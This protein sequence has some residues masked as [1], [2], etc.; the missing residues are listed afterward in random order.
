M[1]EKVGRGP[2]S[3]KDY[4]FIQVTGDA[5]GR[6][7]A[8][9]VLEGHAQAAG[10]E[11]AQVVGQVGVDA[12]DQGLVAEVGVQAKDHF[13]E[14]EVAHPGMDR[15]VAEVPRPVH[16]RREPAMGKRGAELIVGARND[17]ESDEG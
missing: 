7:Y 6:H 16:D 12:A 8:L 3:Q 9:T 13:P 10:Q 11:V 5:R 4:F 2:F 17:R 1:P 15:V 14:E